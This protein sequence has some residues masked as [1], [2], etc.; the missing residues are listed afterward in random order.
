MHF[1]HAFCCNFRYD[2]QFCV[3]EISK[4]KKKGKYFRGN[5]WRTPFKVARP[6][7]LEGQLTFQE[8]FEHLLRRH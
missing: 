2:F 1:V 8:K 6:D 5:P 7:F 4:N 3:N